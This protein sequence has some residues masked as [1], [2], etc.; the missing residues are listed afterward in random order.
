MS[1]RFT[2]VTVALTAV[3]SLLVGLIM[4][5]EFNR[6]SILAGESERSPRPIRTSTGAAPATGVVNFA[7]VV[8]RINPAVVNIE[9]TT[10]NDDTRRRGRPNTPGSPGRPDFRAPQDGP[11]LEPPRRG[12]GSGFI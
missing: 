5:G 4:A 12:S 11:N 10:R 8:D 2:F 1:R 7:D 3:I 6:P 9:A